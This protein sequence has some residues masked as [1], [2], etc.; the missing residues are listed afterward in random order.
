MKSD[1]KLIIFADGGSRGNPGEAAYGFVVYGAD[2]NILH[3]EGKTIGI[4]TNN[5]AEYSG[6][7]NALRWVTKNISAEFFNI[8][9]FLDSLLAAEQLSENY[10]VKN[11]NL[12]SLFFTVKELEKQIPGKVSYQHVRREENK[13]ADRL[14]NKALDREI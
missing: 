6:I 4:N 5:V 14:V 1:T 2:K 3:E 11:E 13:E 12:R 10:K 7:I 9:F 8:D